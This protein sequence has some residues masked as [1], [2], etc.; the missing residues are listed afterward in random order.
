[1]AKDKIIRLA[2]N[3]DVFQMP[4]AGIL[5]KADSD[6][7][8]LQ[9]QKDGP[10]VKEL[11]ESLELGMTP[12]D[13]ATYLKVKAPEELEPLIEILIRRRM[14][15]FATDDGDVHHEGNRRF[16]EFTISSLYSNKDVKNAFEKIRVYVYAPDEINESITK[17][18]GEYSIPSERIT[19]RNVDSTEYLLE[20]PQPGQDV[21]AY[22]ILCLCDADPYLKS[23]LAIQLA[24]LNI[25]Y[26][27][28][29][30]DSGY[31]VV[32]PLV[33]LAGPC[34]QCYMMR[35]ISNLTHPEV[36]SAAMAGELTWIK[37][38]RTSFSPLYRNLVA[39]AVTHL[40]TRHFM[41]MDIDFFSRKRKF[42]RIPSAGSLKVEE[43][44]LFKVPDCRAC[45]DSIRRPG[46]PEFSAR[47][48]VVD[49]KAGGNNGNP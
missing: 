38:G 42:Y 40:L 23:E 45:G 18:L 27:P 14:V 39:I 11:I 2:Q 43:V 8:R 34:M 13:M 16:D 6:T 49:A 12:K 28:I 4:D 17:L 46:R 1:M 30:L 22:T 33:N 10:D 47:D 20:L 25:D 24:R 3:V 32:G 31:L 19:L 29:Q 26:I 21:K 36:M 9:N 5:L 41:G 48:E 35:R 44:N 7:L 15:E 37:R